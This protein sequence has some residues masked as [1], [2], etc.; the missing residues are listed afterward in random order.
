MTKAELQKLWENRIAEYRASGQSVKEWCAS[1]DDVTPRQLWY[2]LRKFKNQKDTSPI[3][4]WL[5]VEVSEQASIDLIA[6]FAR[7]AFGAR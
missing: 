5:P 6:F 7:W 3:T 2:W 1:H 4:R